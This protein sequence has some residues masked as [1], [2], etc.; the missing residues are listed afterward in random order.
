MTKSDGS[1]EADALKE[2]GGIACIT[3]SKPSVRIPNW[4]NFRDDTLWGKFL[5]QEVCE[6]STYTTAEYLLDVMNRNIDEMR[7][8]KSSLLQ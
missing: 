3:L 5:S 1:Q 7:Q 2:S 6:N 4:E 8:T